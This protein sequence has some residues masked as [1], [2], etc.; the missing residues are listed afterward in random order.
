MLQVT[1]KTIALIGLFPEKRNT[2]RLDWCK[3]LWP[4]GNLQKSSKMPARRKGPRI[5][6][7]TLESELW[8]LMCPQRCPGGRKD[9]SM[10]LMVEQMVAG[11]VSGDEERGCE[12]GKC[13][14]RSAQTLGGPQKGELRDS[15]S[16]FISNRALQ[17]AQTLFAFLVHKTVPGALRHNSSTTAEITKMKG[18]HS[19]TLRATD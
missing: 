9:A 10:F 1:F 13:Q 15:W 4:R 16:S 5:T 18:K 2:P 14:R 12:G 11:R 19:L 7:L 17:A 6:S 3:P 8:S